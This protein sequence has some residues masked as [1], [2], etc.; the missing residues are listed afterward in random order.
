MAKSS[1]EAL[2]RWSY[3]PSF[4]PLT[5]I[6]VL[7]STSF[8]GMCSVLQFGFQ[9][10]TRCPLYSRVRLMFSKENIINTPKRRMWRNKNFQSADDC[11]WM[12]VKT[13]KP[14]GLGPGSPPSS[15]QAWLCSLWASSLH[16][17]YPPRMRVRAH[18]IATEMESYCDFPRKDLEK[19]HKLHCTLKR[20]LSVRT[21]LSESCFRLKG[22]EGK[23]WEMCRDI[24]L[25]PAMWLKF[26]WTFFSVPYIHPSW[27]ELMVCLKMPSKSSSCF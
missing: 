20:V 7:G 14:P 23:G 26:W 18:Q 11:F 5:A 3:C 21:F 12:L 2:H 6:L 19:Q 9:P 10:R 25:E 22:L 17:F 16:H 1:L 24:P 13:A 4:L 8:P 27:S 15:L